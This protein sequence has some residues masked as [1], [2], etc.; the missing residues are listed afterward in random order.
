MFSTLLYVKSSIWLQNTLLSFRALLRKVLRENYKSHEFYLKLKDIE[1]D[2]I[3][4]NKFC[5]KR[6][7]RA[8]NNAVNH[9]PFYHSLQVVDKTS[10]NSF[11][12]ISKDDVRSNPVGFQSEQKPKLVINGST[13]GTT[14]APLSIAQSMESILIEQAFIA[15]SLD[16]CGYKNGDKR[17]WIRADMIVPIAQQYPPFWRYSYFEDMI[18]LS[19]FHM[20]ADAIPLYLT[21][22]VNY[23]VD[24]IQALPSSIVTLAKYLEI[25]NEYYSGSLKSILTSSESLSTEN[26]KLVE[27][28]FRCTV[29]DWYGLFERVAA[30]ASCE[31][32]RYHILTDYS[33]VEFLPAGEV[34]GAQRVE[35]VGTNFNNS[36]YPL[37][38]YKTGDHVVLSDESSCPCGRVFP[39]VKN[40]EGRNF[41]AIFAYNGT[42]IFDLDSCCIGVE[43]LL[44]SQ[45]IQDIEKEINVMVVSTLNFTAKEKKK[46]IVNVRARL[47][48]LMVV[49]VCEINS[50]IRTKNGKV[51]QAICNI[52]KY[53]E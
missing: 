46:L 36:F 53:D 40:I 23:N 19:S 22:M 45:Y 21:A 3:A 12:Y 26:K 43:G 13:S 39:M 16:W 49:K 32:G 52:K 48:D 15:R 44:G 18:M 41:A 8:L 38:R 42:P 34:N 17:A 51:I 1:Y 5:K 10:L 14:G 47:G 7:E 33:H 11:P 2:S 25:N 28:R 9:V 50:L 6:L 24:I 20:S 35:I 4:L 27:E 37:I 30:I 29:F 31:H